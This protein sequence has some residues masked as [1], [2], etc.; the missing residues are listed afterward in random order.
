MCR[1]NSLAKSPLDL[2]SIDKRT[3]QVIAIKTIDLESAEDEIE[4]IQ[5]EIAMLSQLTSDHVTR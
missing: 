4:D 1:K 2:C 3:N 5:S